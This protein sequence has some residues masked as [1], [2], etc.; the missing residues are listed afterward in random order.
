MK[1]YDLGKLLFCGFILYLAALLVRLPGISTATPQADELH[2]L[3]RSQ[4]ILT[5][6]KTG[7]YLNLT[8]HCTHPGVPP[9]LV[10]AFGQKISEKW[11]SSRGLE[12]YNRGYVDRLTAARVSNVLASSLLAPVVFAGVVY[13]L[14]LIPALL[15]TVFVIF[16][17]HIIGLSRLAHLDALLCVFVVGACF[18][19]AYALQNASLKAKL[20]AGLLWG[21]AITTKP[22]AG[23]LVV[24]FLAVKFL[25][26]FFFSRDKKNRGENSIF[27]WSDVGAVLLGL[28]VLSAMFTRM[29]HHNSDYRI[30]L[31]ISN[32]AADLVYA[33]GTSLQV[34]HLPWLILGVFVLYSALCFFWER[35]KSYPGQRRNALICSWFLL[36]ALLLLAWVPQVLENT[37]RFWTWVVQLSQARHEAYGIWWEP[38]KHGYPMLFA[39]EVTTVGCLGAVLGLMFLVRHLSRRVGKK[40]RERHFFLLYIALVLVLWILPLTAATKQT[41]RYVLPVV[42]LFYVLAAY[43]YISFARFLRLLLRVNCIS[44]SRYLLGKSVVPGVFA[45]A[46]FCQCFTTFLWAY[47]YNLYFNSLTGGIGGAYRRGTTFLPSGIPEAMRFLHEKSAGAQRKQVVMVMGDLQVVQYAYARE[48]PRD[49]RC[50]H[51]RAPLGAAG[52]D[53]LL[54]FSNFKRRVKDREWKKVLSEKPVFSYM[55]KGIPIVEVYA[56]PLR[57]YRAGYFIE[58]VRS[59]R[60]VGGEWKL[61]PSVFAELKAKGN[62]SAVIAEP[63]RHPRGYL[64]HGEQARH[65]PGSYEAVFWLSLLPGV[66]LNPEYGPERYSVRLEY[67]RCE[68]IVTLGELS[69]LEMKPFILPCD[70]N[71]EVQAQLRIYWFGNIPTALGGVELFQ[72]FPN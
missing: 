29:W 49:E 20:G 64:L 40:K 3:T 2:W 39:S 31:G 7:D 38:P 14:G 43:G 47:D 41:F 16:D 65:L 52:A 69:A 68:R 54:V 51:L 8:T 25:R 10:M 27:S 1:R 67:G 61:E 59:A 50:L 56:V 18:L 48:F 60:D 19:Y 15:C 57:D 11:N 58:P 28:L 9:A 6:F 62:T 53:Y 34:F 55:V 32:R 36:F 45:L 23:S 42:P 63:G 72:R 4:K 5:K 22:T 12:Q 17:P 21:L 46:V 30:R 24:V 66:S 70:F 37:F 44:Q 35:S 26:F 13:F 71:R 33:A